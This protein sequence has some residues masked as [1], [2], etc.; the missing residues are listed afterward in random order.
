[1]SIAD[2]TGLDFG[3]GLGIMGLE[4]QLRKSMDFLSL[5]SPV[6]FLARPNFLLFG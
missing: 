5:F 3:L 1:V 2:W 6:F 4:A